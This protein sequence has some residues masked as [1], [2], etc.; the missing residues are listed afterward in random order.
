MNG[1]KMLE[2]C[3][4]AREKKGTAD[5]ESIA[6]LLGVVKSSMSVKGSLGYCQSQDDQIMAFKN[7]EIVLPVSVGFFYFACNARPQQLICR[8]GQV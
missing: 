1:I 6:M 3:L 4:T 5:L 8:S 2:D 7:M